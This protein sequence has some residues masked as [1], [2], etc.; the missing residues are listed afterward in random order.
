M[1]AYI[2]KKNIAAIQIDEDDYIKFFVKGNFISVSTSGYIRVNRYLGVKDRK[3]LYSQKYLHRLIMGAK[4]G[5]EVDH[6]N[7]DRMDVRKKNLRL[8]KPSENAKN[9]RAVKGKYKGVH[10]SKKPKRWVAQITKDY[11]CYHI[12]FF[13]SA[14]E[15]AKAYNEKAKE[16]HG[17]FAYLNTL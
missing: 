7:H 3:S 11:R 8:C 13:H 6:I 17:E 12:G 2:G 1:K 15:A 14:K 16:L 4:K 10:F 9:R 5:E